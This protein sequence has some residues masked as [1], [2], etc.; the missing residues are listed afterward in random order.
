MYKEQTQLPRPFHPS[1]F[2]FVTNPRLFS[3]LLLQYSATHV[4]FLLIV[5]LFQVFIFLK[6]FEI[7]FLF[8]LLNIVYILYIYKLYI[9]IHIYMS[10]YLVLVYFFL[11]SPGILQERYFETET[12][13]CLDWKDAHWVC[14]SF[15]FWLLPKPH[16]S[17]ISHFH[18]LAIIF[19]SPCPLGFEGPTVFVNFDL[20]YSTNVWKKWELNFCL[21]CRLCLEND[22]YI[23]KSCPTLTLFQFSPQKG[24]MVRLPVGS[25]GA[26][27]AYG[28][29]GAVTW[30]GGDWNSCLISV[31]KMGVCGF[32]KNQFLNG[33]IDGFLYFG[34]G[35]DLWL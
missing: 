16:P 15:L 8:F 11:W 31:N 17:S 18:I 22:Y 3:S 4:H 20:I 25:R 27:L 19:F 28:A 10:G 33:G 30:R 1:S 23:C 24:H 6:K 9:Y 34:G 7:T 35:W 5:F 2:H 26:E 12:F 29:P 32:Y 21:R 13:L 14:T